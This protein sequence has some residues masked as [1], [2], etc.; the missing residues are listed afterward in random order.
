MLDG[1]FMYGDQAGVGRA[2]KASGV[3]RAEVFLISKFP[4]GG[5][6]PKGG[7]TGVGGSVFGY[8]ETLQSFELSL[9]QLQA[10]MHRPNRQ[11]APCTVAQMQRGADLVRDGWKDRVSGCRAW[12]RVAGGLRGPVPLALV[13]GPRPR[14]RPAARSLD[15]SIRASAQRSP[16]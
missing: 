3:P 6:G 15:L 12:R 16:R 5:G 14:P 10:R 1:A 11:G 2:I 13:A 8:N 4:S 7:P 9:Q